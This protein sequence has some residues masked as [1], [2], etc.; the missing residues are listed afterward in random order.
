VRLE[1]ALEMEREAADH[2]KNDSSVYQEWKSAAQSAI[3]AE[4]SF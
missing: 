4:D 1:V 2:F 3:E